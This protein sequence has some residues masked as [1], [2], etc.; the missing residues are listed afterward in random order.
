MIVECFRF[1][2]KTAKLDT[3]RDN[4][5]L[6]FSEAVDIQWTDFAV[7]GKQIDVI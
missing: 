6:L 1:Q 5:I 3:N 4:E 2:S 7:K